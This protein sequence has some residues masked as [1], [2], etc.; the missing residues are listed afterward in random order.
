MG[1]NH[2]TSRKEVQEAIIKLFQD[3][4][5]KMDFKKIS[6]N[7]EQVLNNLI[8]V[9]EGLIRDHPDITKRLK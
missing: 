6:N 3:T 7:E 2:K 4:W 1:S 9:Q 5:S 8:H